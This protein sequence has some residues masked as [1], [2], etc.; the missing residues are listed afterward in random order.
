[1]LVTET[2]TGTATPSS[3]VTDDSN[4]KRQPQHHGG[5]TPSIWLMTHFEGNSN[6]KKFPLKK[7]QWQEQ[8]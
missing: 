2:Q 1:L 3:S 4:T 5:S 7:W 8:S 6:G